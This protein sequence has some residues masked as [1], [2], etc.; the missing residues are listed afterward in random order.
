MKTL[1]K[2]NRPGLLAPAVLFLAAAAAPSI[3]QQAPSGAQAAPQSSQPLPDELQRAK[4]LWTTMAAIDH[5]NQSGNYSVLRDL[6]APGFQL[7]NDAARLAQIFAGIRQLNVD[8]SNTLL[9]APTYARAPAIEGNGL[10]RMQGS[11]N[12]RPTAILFD[13]SYQWYGNRWRLMGVSIGARSV[14]SD[15]AAPRPAAPPPKK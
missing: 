13:F 2:R 4:L 3:A 8:L 5:A 6:S 10:L 15:Q 14:G 11:F 1:F 9:L 7:N 12:L